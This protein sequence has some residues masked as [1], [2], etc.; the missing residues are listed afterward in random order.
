MRKISTILLSVLTLVLML[1][2]SDAKASAASEPFFGRTLSTENIYKGA[3]DKYPVAGSAK[4][5][6]ELLVLSS[7]TNSAGESWYRVRSKN[8]TGWV[9]SSKVKSYGINGVEVTSSGTSAAV[10]K[11]AEDSYSGNST[12]SSF[13]TAFVIDSIVNKKGEKWV[14]VTNFLTGSIETGWLRLDNIKPV[15]IKTNISTKIVYPNMGVSSTSTLN[16]AKD[17]LKY[18][19]P[20]RIIG[21]FDNTGNEFPNVKIAYGTNF[22]KTGWIGYVFTQHAYRD[23]IGESFD[24]PAASMIKSSAADSSRTAASLKE[25]SKVTVLD[26]YVNESSFW[27]RVQASSG[28]KGW[29][30]IP[31]EYL[32]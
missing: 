17:Y 8:V 18:G 15:S 32:N 12:L 13:E 25:G 4:S 16:D 10:R 29:L 31:N 27:L 19:A 28:V 14:R 22:S 26:V 1:A 5:S 2:V 9:L 30:K 3:T 7:F 20:V 6:E 11:G 23:A 24:L 21:A